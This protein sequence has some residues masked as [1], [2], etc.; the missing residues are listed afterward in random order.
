MNKNEIETVLTELS[1]VTGFRVSLHDAEYHEIAAFPKEALPFCALI[2]AREDEHD[3]CIECDR[4][5]CERAVCNHETVIYKCRYGLIESVSPIYNF[6][7]LTGFLMMGQ[8]AQSEA[9]KDFAVR[10][11]AHVA[12]AADIGKSIPVISR[13]MIVSYA[14]IMSICAKYL[15]LANATSSK[16]APIASGASEYINKHLSEKIKIKDVCERLGCSKTTLI[17]AFKTEHGITVNEYINN[18][19]LT[20]AEKLIMSTDMSAA[21]V[22]YAVGFGDQAYFSKVFSKRFGAP[23]A[24]YRASRKEN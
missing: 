12:G 23:P 20:K 7:E 5:A 16:K 24:K 6:G 21:D 11:A 18:Q 4:I 15:T 10:C 1:H 22:A 2:N 14:R 19:R 3:M 9:D 13:E 8:V 17:N